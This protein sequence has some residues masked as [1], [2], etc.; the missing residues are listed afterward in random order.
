MYIYVLHFMTVS[1]I[2]N[3][4]FGMTCNRHWQPM[5]DGLFEHGNWGIAVEKSHNVAQEPQS[6]QHSDDSMY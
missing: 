2:N 1:T 3:L 5:L 6:H 4:S